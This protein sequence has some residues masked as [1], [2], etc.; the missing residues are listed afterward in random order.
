MCFAKEDVDLKIRE[1]LVEAYTRQ[2]MD[3]AWSSYSPP[4]AIE[5]DLKIRCQQCDQLFDLTVAEQE[6]YQ[7]ME[8]YSTPHKCQGCNDRVLLRQR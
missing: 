6:F 4:P 1:L 7:R 8:Y 2:H 5:S 3:G